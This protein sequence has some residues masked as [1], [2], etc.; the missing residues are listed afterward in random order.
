MGRAP[1][2]CL[3]DSEGRTRLKAA[4][5]RASPRGRWY[6]GGGAC[7]TCTSA[8]AE[9]SPH[10]RL[11]AQGARLRGI[12]PL[13]HKLGHGFGARQAGGVSRGRYDVTGSMRLAGDG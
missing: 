2:L 4:H 5:G 11:A 7:L 8:A 6:K 3:I 12:Q 9:R 10:A 13:H 1:S